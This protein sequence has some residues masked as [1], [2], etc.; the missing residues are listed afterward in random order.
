MVTRVDRPARSRSVRQEPARPVMPAVPPARRP[1]Q[2]VPQGPQAAGAARPGPI[3][4]PRWVYPLVTFVALLLGAEAIVR[5]TRAVVSVADS[6]LTNFFFPSADYI[7]RGQPWQM[8]GVRA[9]GGYPNYNPPLSIWLMSPLLGL[10]RTFGFDR[11]NG[12][13]ITFVSLPF[14]V[15][16]PLLGW[17]VLRALRALYP[18]M[19][20][21]QR[22]LAYVLIVL[23]PLTWQSIATWYHIEQPMMLC[24]LIAALIALQARREEIA[25]ALA[26][27]ALLSRTTAL[28]PL[29]ALGVLLVA[30]RERRALVR[31]AGVAGAVVAVGLAPFF[32]F[33]PANAIYSFLTWRGSAIIGGNSIW[34][35]FAAG[36]HATGLR[37]TLDAL[38]RR[39]DMPSVVIFLAVVAYLAARRLRIS[40]YS[41]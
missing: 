4:V 32:L 1:E 17:L 3:G 19:P 30:G 33:D 34:S 12:E 29:L 39:L 8:Y 23:S 11:N 10:A 36:D 27:L 2:Y 24:F 40:A 20:E 9:S 22:L 7:L 14:I 28:M 38:A 18:Q 25:G 13:L 31:F 6:D 15:F 26:G 5:G 37:L 21:T 16:V 41:R 35:L